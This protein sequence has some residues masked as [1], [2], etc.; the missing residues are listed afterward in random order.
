MSTVVKCVFLHSL[1]ELL[2]TVEYSIQLAVAC[3]TGPVK[4]LRISLTA[5]G[6]L[7]VQQEQSILTSKKGTTVMKWLSTGQLVVGR[8]G[9]VTVWSQTASTTLLLPIESYRGWTS[10]SPPID[11]VHIRTEDT[12]VVALTDGTFRI[13][14]NLSSVPTAHTLESYNNLP[15]LEL[16][17]SIHRAFRAIEEAAWVSKTPTVPK[18]AYMNLT[19]FCPIDHNGSAI[20]AY[21]RYTKDVKIFRATVM[22]R[23]SFAIGR[24]FGNDLAPRSTHAL[25]N[26]LVASKP[27]AHSCSF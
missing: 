13:V 7:F 21:E 4:I 20:W 10:C 27:G 11:V 17:D 26:L 23:T 24:T 1:T 16:N 15:S 2:C 3:A 25:H 5:D 14:S 19:G 22:H 18:Q 8:L 6:E 9:E 12:L